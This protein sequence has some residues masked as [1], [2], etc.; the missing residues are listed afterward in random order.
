MSASRCITIAST[1]CALLAVTS[2]C[3]PSTKLPPTVPVT[4]NVTF[5]G[6]PVEGATVTFVPVDAMTGKTASGDTDAQGNFQLQTFVAATT[7]AKGALVGDYKVTVTK[8]AD[9]PPPMAAPKYME[10]GTPP[11]TSVGMKGGPEQAKI[12]LPAN[13]A[14]AEK[15]GF[16]A[17]VKS[18]GNQ[19]FTFAL[20]GE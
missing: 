18:S 15:S 3:G 8:M 17:N 11:A 7:Q 2:G 14:D 1:W 12:V 9:A 5:N 6:S 13:Y 19:P 10:G 16:T 20:T 4:G